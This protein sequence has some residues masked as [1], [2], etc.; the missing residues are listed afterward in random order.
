[1]RRLPK[2]AYFDDEEPEKEWISV[3]SAGEVCPFCGHKGHEKDECMNS[4][5][6]L[7]EFASKDM[8]SET[9]TTQEAA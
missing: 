5:L 4:V 8:T 2:R 6:F 7:P 1:M 3:M 9:V